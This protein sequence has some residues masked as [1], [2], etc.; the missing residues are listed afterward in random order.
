MKVW[1]SHSSEHSA[2]I[3]LV[4][5]FKTVEDANALMKELTEFEEMLRPHAQECYDAPER[6]PEEV[7]NAL[8]EGKKFPHA[9]YVYSGELQQFVCD[10]DLD[11]SENKV[12]IHSDE[13]EWGGV[14]KMLITAGAKISVFSSHDYPEDAK[15]YAQ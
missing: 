15:K 9:Q 8:Y 14:L 1:N 10:H 6:Y 2:K 7:K 11:Q 5:E 12:V 3:V 13:Y 4:G